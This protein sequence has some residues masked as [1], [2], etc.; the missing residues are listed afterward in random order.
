MRK[1]AAIRKQV[2]HHIKSR[3]Q[4]SDFELTES[5]C[6]YWWR[7]LNEAVFDGKLTPPER[8]EFRRFHHNTAGWCQPYRMNRANRRVRIGISTRIQDRKTFLEILG[9]E[10]VHQYEW[11]V[12]HDW[13]ETKSEHGSNFY[14]WCEPLARRVGLTLDTH[15]DI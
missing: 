12:D 4:N 9:H 8:F 10:M 14:K 15:Y 5:F 2:K 6:M 11:E 3:G 13:D 1:R 7:H